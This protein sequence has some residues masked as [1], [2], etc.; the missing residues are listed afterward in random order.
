[1]KNQ[2]DKEQSISSLLHFQAL[3]EE[4]D[5]GEM[6]LTGTHCDGAIPP[7]GV[8]KCKLVFTFGQPPKGLSLRVGAGILTDAVYF[9]LPQGP[10]GQP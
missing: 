5:Q 1:M 4:G 8:F 10:S 9:N 6:D 2:S 7:N 3:S